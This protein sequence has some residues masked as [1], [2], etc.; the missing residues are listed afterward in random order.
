[1]RRD[2]KG[3]PVRIKEKLGVG[4]QVYMQ[5]ENVLL[6]SFRQK[7]SQTKPALL[8]TTKYKTNTVEIV[9]KKK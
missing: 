1:M 5:N 2:R 8:L 9:K 3:L 7:K 4:H 6:L